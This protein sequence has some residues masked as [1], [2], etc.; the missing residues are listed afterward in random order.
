MALTFKN[1]Q[2]EVLS[3][4]YGEN[5][6]ARVR[7][8]INA[9]Y[10]DIASRARWAWTQASIAV[11][12]TPGQPFVTLSSSIDYWGRL[13]PAESGVVVPQFVDWQGFNNDFIVVAPDDLADGMPSYYSLWNDAIYFNPVPDDVY[14]YTA[15]CWATPVDLSADTDEPQI[16]QTDRAVLVVG[17]LKHASARDKDWNAYSRWENQ[18]EGMVAKMRAKSNMKQTETPRR[19]PMPEEYGGVFG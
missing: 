2:D 7:M 15:E 16:M 9:A 4:G 3:Y 1:I 14:Q 17:A 5:D 12:T 8:W 19:I 11:A 10:R 13:R 6:R 18:Y